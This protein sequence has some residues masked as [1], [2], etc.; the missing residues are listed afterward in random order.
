MS[1]RL[2]KDFNIEDLIKELRQFTY[3]TDVEGEAVT[4]NV[5]LFTAGQV[6]LATRLFLQAQG[7]RLADSILYSYDKEEIT[8]VQLSDIIKVVCV[9][10][11]KHF[12]EMWKVNY[13]PIWNVDG[14]E[15]R[16]IV[17]EYGKVTEMEKGTTLTDEQKTNGTDTTQYGHTLTDEQKTNGEDS[18]TYGQKLTDEQKTA[19]EDSTTYGQKLTDEQKTNGEDSTTFGKV[20]TSTHPTTTNTVAAFDS[21]NFVDHSEVSN[22]NSSDTDSGTEA[23]THTIGKIEH[24]N[25]GQD[26][27][28]HDMG[29]IEHSTSGTDSTTHSIGKLEH[30]E[31]GSDTI[32]H[33]L[34]K[35][36]HAN[37]GKDTDTESGTDTVTDTFVRAGNIG[38]TMTQQL[39]TAEESFWSKYS[40]FEHWFNDIAE[41]IGLPIW[42]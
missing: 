25:S 6:P 14:K 22:T 39:L 29:K 10:R 18:T 13:N 33:N 3:T 38:V 34:G 40:F 42:G 1:K 35:I 12:L 32:T 9:Q 17:T 28:T 7:D 20:V 8:A 21:V 36:E 11:W 31:T 41:Q 30:A 26:T 15:V 19:G 5:E 24:A 2:I 37:S 27:T 4:V 23:T 16:T